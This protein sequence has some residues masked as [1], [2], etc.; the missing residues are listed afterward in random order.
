MLHMV[1]HFHMFNKAFLLTRTVAHLEG[2]PC[3]NL[4]V[5]GSIHIAIWKKR[6]LFLIIF[7]KCIGYSGSDLQALCEE[8]AM[9]PIRELGT[10]ILTV[11]AN[12]V[13]Y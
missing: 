11:R 2:S 4:K 8:A 7:F 3:H 1:L 5:V 6:G 12:Q 9:M 10:N 13:C